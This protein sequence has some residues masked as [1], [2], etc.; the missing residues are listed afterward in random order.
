MQRIDLSSPHPR[1]NDE[2]STTSLLASDRAFIQF[3]IVT[4]KDSV[5]EHQIQTV[6]HKETRMKNDSSESLIARPRRISAGQRP[7]GTNGR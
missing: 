6:L 1:N 5:E 2:I 3:D 4:E 7:R